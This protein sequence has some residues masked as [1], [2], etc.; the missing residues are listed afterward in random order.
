MGKSVVDRVIFVAIAFKPGK[1]A[2]T[3]IAVAIVKDIAVAIAAPIAPYFG[4]RMI[5]NP[6]FDTAPNPLNRGRS[7]VLFE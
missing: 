5:F 3:V 7:F 1:K 4:I 2:T 6:I